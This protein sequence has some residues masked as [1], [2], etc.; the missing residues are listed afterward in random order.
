MK[1][2]VARAV[3][4][5]AA[6]CL[7]VRH[8]AWGKAMR[9]EFDAVPDDGA[10]LSFAAGC[11]VAAWREMLRCEEGW[12]TLARYGLVLALMLPM[13]ALQV[14]CALFGLPYLYPDHGG[15]AAAMVVGREHEVL[16]RATYQAAVPVLAVLLLLL[17]VGHL[18]IAWAL[19][20]DDWARTRRLG[21]AGLAV[22]LTLILLMTVLFL[23]SRQALLQAAILGVELAGIGAAAWWHHRSL[24]SLVPDRRG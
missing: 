18:L 6:A 19:L 1:R 9:A 3:M 20:E 7:P 16:I 12:L 8:A 15:V 2:L 17:G 23:D 4:D 5:V 22:A 10:P 24:T 11:L 13:A 14:G 21:M